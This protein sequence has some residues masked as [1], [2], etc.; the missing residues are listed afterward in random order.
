MGL[1]STHWRGEFE[2]HTI[3]VV[4]KWGGHEFELHIDCKTVASAASLANMGERKLEGTLDHAGA[5]LAVH[6]VGTQGAFTERATV[7]VGERT[8]EMKKIA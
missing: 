4:R 6:A 3:E 1:F 5:T 2:G 8:I 7:V